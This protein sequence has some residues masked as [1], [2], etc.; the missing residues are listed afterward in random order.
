MK[1]GLVKLY[2]ANPE[3]L[4]LLSQ[5]NFQVSIM[6]PNEEIATISASQSNADEWV[7]KYVLP[8]YPKTK[9][10]FLLVGN[11]VLSDNSEKGQNIW[12]HLVPAMRRIHTSLMAHNIKNIKVS[13]PIAMDAIVTTFPPSS[14]TFRPGIRET[15]IVPMLDF[16]QRTNSFFFIDV[17][18]YFPWSLNPNN[19]S[20]EFALLGGNFNFTDTS[21]GLFYTNLLDQMLDSVIFA[22]SK[23]GFPSIRL[24]ISETGWPHSGDVGEDAGA[25]AF[26]AA[27]YNRNLIKKITAKP[28]LGT[29][30]RPGVFIPTFIFSLY[31]ENLK[32]GPGIERHWGLLHPNG[33]P[34]Y[35]IYLTGKRDSPDSALKNNSMNA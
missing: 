15:V 3:I 28:P 13:T 29:P 22:M 11:E 23:L 2:D 14:G 30:A 33:T 19:I 5:T 21:S 27:M 34:V 4:N 8:Y 20:L 24:V 1:A 31:D 16:L 32:I 10:R 12:L 17:Y 26:N 6:I 25:N 35:E 7:R 9:I 18:T